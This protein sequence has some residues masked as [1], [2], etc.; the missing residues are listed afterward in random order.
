MALILPSFILGRPIIYLNHRLMMLESAKM[1]RPVLLCSYVLILA[2]CGGGSP[3]PSQI[4]AIP[5]PTDGGSKQERTMAALMR[6]HPK[7]QRKE[8][9]YDARLAGVA[10]A[11][12]RDMATRKYFS[13]INP[14]GYGS[15]WHVAKTGYR[16]PPQWLAFKGSNQ[17]ESLL[18]G[19][20]NVE[21]GFARWLSSGTH[22]NHILA[23]N[24]FYQDQ[25]RYG[26]GYHYD[27]NAPFCHYWVLVTAPPEY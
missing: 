24:P 26:L 19:E 22:R 27:P 25:T 23:L 21:P 11:K 3:H 15:N 14:E 1:I 12:A 4:K 16:L 17:G 18:A 5:I 2:S 20:E 13:H 7:Q 10:R 8:F 9:K 6:G